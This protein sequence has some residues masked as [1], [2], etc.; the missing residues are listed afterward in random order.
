MWI[1][2]FNEIVSLCRFQSDVY[3]RGLVYTQVIWE[4]ADTPGQ[5]SCFGQLDGDTGHV[6]KLSSG[7]WKHDIPNVGRQ[8]LW[9]TATGPHGS[10]TIMAA[11]RTASLC[12]RSV[13][14][15]GMICRVTTRPALSAK[16]INVNRRL[17]TVSLTVSG[18]TVCSLY[19]SHTNCLSIV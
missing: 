8:F 10:L 11:E 12:G 5:A 2:G 16:W 17:S 4:D 1:L 6:A 15:F 18:D 9:D 13:A 14:T 19:L 3:L 7:W